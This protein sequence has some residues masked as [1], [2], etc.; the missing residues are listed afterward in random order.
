[1]KK[2]EKLSESQAETLLVSSPNN[3]EDETSAT[4]QTDDGVLLKTRCLIDEMFYYYTYVITEEG[5]IVAPGVT[6]SEQE[7]IAELCEYHEYHLQP[8]WLA[9]RIEADWSQTVDNSVQLLVLQRPERLTYHAK[10]RA[11]MILTNFKK[12]IFEKHYAR[13]HCKA[14]WPFVHEDTIDDMR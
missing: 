2:S 8:G 6:P 4:S 14:E 12:R 3:R 7:Y 1:M 13:A 10:K 11:N 5:L 9:V